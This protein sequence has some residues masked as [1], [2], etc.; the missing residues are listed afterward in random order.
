V[1]G[2]V[3]EPVG[4]AH[5]DWDTAAANLG[6]AIRR[7]LD[8]LAGMDAAELCRQ[9]YERFRRMGVYQAD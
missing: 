2:V 8:E 3:P 9:R 4:G 1:D 7:D 6:E 5:R